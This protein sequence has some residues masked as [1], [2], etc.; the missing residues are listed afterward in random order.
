MKNALRHLLLWCVI[1][2]ITVDILIDWLHCTVHIC[3]ALYCKY[4]RA[5]VE[6]KI[7]YIFFIFI[8]VLVFTVFLYFTVYIGFFF[9]YL[10]LSDVST[11]FP[12]ETPKFPL[13]GT[14][15][16]YL[17]SSTFRNAAHFLVAQPHLVRGHAP[18]AV[19]W[20]GQIYSD[21]EFFFD[22]LQPEIQHRKSVTE[23]VLFLFLYPLIFLK[24]SCLDTWVCCSW[25]K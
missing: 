3:T 14:I 2:K 12:A 25:V 6:I 16:D 10:F 24:F 23:K 8:L 1:L 17:I 21:T 20:W 13:C 5:I 22:I 7:A 18:M 9:H 11:H 19:F 15:K 4:L